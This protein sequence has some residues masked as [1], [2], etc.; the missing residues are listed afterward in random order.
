V[1]LAAPLVLAVLLAACG[2]DASPPGDDQVP[3]RVVTAEGEATLRVEIA[4]TSEERAAGLSGRAS[5]PADAGMAF[6]WD[7]P[8]EAE[9]WMKDTLIPLQIAFWDAGG[10]IIALIEMEPCE[11]DP[12]PTYGPDAPIVGAVEANSGWFT[13]HGVAVGD[14]VELDAGDA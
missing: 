8:V 10:R 14:T 4:D 1:R 12:C 11:A 13:A 5:V 9:F 3:L 2:S 6:L 7:E